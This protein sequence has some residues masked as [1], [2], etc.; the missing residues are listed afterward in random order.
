MEN[1]I[2]KMAKAINQ[3]TF[4]INDALQQK[5]N[6]VEDQQL[7][8]AQ[9]SINDI[10]VATSMYEKQLK[11]KQAHTERTATQIAIQLEGELSDED[12]AAALENANSAAQAVEEISAEEAKALAEWS[13]STSTAM[14]ELNTKLGTI[15]QF[16]A[17]FVVTLGDLIE[18][19]L[20]GP[21][22]S[23]AEFKAVAG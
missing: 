13:E 19:P 16:D 17:T 3:N 1:S 14:A 9:E 23:F 8:N 15:G 20:F 21:T 22:H 10:G 5:R 11:Y 4:E 6:A 12:K 2:Q 18:I 7:D